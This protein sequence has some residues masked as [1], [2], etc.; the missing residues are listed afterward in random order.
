MRRS[1]FKPVIWVAGL[2]LLGLSAAAIFRSGAASA[3]GVAA[4]GAGSWGA[5]AV[6]GVASSQ[7][8]ATGIPLVDFF[9]GGGAYM[10]RTH[11]MV[12]QDGST[13]WPWVW[14]MLGLNVLIIAGYLRIF[15]FWRRAYLQEAREDRNNK[16]MELA[17]IFL[18]CAVCGYI[19]S[20]VLFFWPGY[21]LLALALVP[22]A[23]FTWK[24]AAN[25][26]GFRISL[27]AKR[28]AR[29]LNESL[30]LQN[31]RL[32]E[33]VRVAT[34]DLEEAK[35][36]AE[37]ANSAKSEFLAR[38]SHEIR[39]PLTAI[40]GYVDI[41]LDTDVPGDE[42]MGHLRTVQRN[43][44]H[45][46]SLINDVLDVS[47]IEAGE[48]KY[49]RVPCSI[50]E[51]IDDVV[52]LLRAQA[53]GKRLRL[54]ASTGERVPQWVLT[55]PVRVRQMVSN[56][57]G[58]AIKFT[59]DG[60][61]HVSVNIAEGVELEDESE[62]ALEI[63]VRDTGIGMTPEQLGRVFE[64]FVQAEGNTERYFGGTGL[65]LS[66]AK[67]IACD[68]GGDL[69]ATST[70]GMGSTFTATIMTREAVGESFA[71][72]VGP[73]A[74]VKEG[75]EA[76]DLLVSSRVLLVEDSADNTRLIKHHF[77]KIG[78]E[79]EHAHDGVMG[80]HAAREA[81]RVGH[82]YDL[83]LMDINMPNMSGI[84]CLRELRQE[85]MGV[86]VVM[87]SAH[88]IMEEQERCLKAGASAYVTKP[89]SFHDLF[90]TC[91]QLLAERAQRQAA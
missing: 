35:A 24:F 13:D 3:S 33:Q 37:Q 58:N 41:A 70:Q 74:D 8:W 90:L 23:F 25:L 22:L 51:I 42:R 83:V 65:G 44:E 81:S 36:A 7:A 77:R 27:S 87:L 31:E 66:I 80:L 50:R 16:L 29:E 6:C 11:C 54:S 72:C 89:I 86:P 21:R 75:I 85:G 82:P 79:L 18:F 60:D 55:D 48:M 49:E 14:G 68:L 78:V 43:S 45:L 46:L 67:Q 32:S 15:I 56:L 61:V 53:S 5:D 2:A 57:V 38:V 39:I 26:E 76:D 62:I 20:I 52:S 9:S 10:A 64:R 63:A 1:L 69:S 59:Q 19:S 40:L 30:Q 84:E 71:Y 88:A 28:L 47:K 91:E 17:W 12:T 73:V 34:R 4:R